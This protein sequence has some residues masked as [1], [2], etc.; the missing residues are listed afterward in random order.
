L[1]E[2]INAATL[3]KP[4]NAANLAKADQRNKL[5]RSRSTR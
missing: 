2:P 1:A 5:R 3:S 4:I